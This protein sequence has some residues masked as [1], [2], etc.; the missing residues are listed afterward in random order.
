MKWEEPP[1]SPRTARGRTWKAEAAE[2]RAHP[3]Q[4]AVIAERPRYERS[5]AYDLSVNVKQGR[6]AAFRPS[7]SFE[8][9]VRLDGDMHKVYARYVGTGEKE[10]DDGK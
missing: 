2:L 3:G 10:K 9:A 8:A 6:I 5:R 1:L 7:G 4:W